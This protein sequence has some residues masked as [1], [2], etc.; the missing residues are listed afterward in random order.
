M[1]RAGEAVR[2]RPVNG[3]HIFRFKSMPSRLPSYVRI[4]RAKKPSLLTEGQDVPRIEVI[5]PNARVDRSHL[6]RYRAVCGIPSSEFLPLE[7]PHLISMPLQLTLLTCKAFPIGVLGFVHIRNWIRQLRPL[8]PDS[9]G[10]LRTWI[11][12]HRETDQGQE[13][14]IHTEWHVSNEPVWSEVTTYLARRMERPKRDRQ[15]AGARDRTRASKVKSFDQLQPDSAT[16]TPIRAE[17][18]L[19]RRYASLS[20]DYNPIHLTD[21]TAR[22]FGFDRAIIH[23]MWSLARCA[24]SMRPEIQHQPCELNLQ[25]KLPVRLPANLVLFQWDIE[26]GEAFALRNAENQRAHLSGA[27]TLVAEH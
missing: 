1:S 11:E 16:A 3:P 18:G 14:D 20:G 9:T 25:F 10:E 23:G 4:L 27:L 2:E 22:W 5:L 19:G 17:A 7:Y 24:A 12:G 21:Y 6:A 15:N 8:T 26:N 13:F